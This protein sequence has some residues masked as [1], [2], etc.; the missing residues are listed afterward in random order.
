MFSPAYC[1]LVQFELV[2][3]FRPRLPPEAAEL[4]T[5]HANDVARSP[6]QPRVVRKVIFDAGLARID[7]PTN[8][9]AFIRQHV[10]KPQ[11]VTFV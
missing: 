3:R 6:F 1:L 4:L 2:Q 10:Y 8:M 5:V 11:Y 9:V 7:R